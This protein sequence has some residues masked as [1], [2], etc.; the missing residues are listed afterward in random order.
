MRG[1]IYFEYCILTA[2]RRY[3]KP[4]FAD[5]FLFFGLSF[6]LIVSY[7]HLKS[8][9]FVAASALKSGSDAD[10]DDDD[11]LDADIGNEPCP[12]GP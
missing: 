6:M 1:E 7:M 5:L 8:N 11:D 3:G 4:E 2:Y 10:D 9:P 12:T